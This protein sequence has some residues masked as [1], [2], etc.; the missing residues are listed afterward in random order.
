MN[1]SNNSSPP[2]H[3]SNITE[4]P[5]LNSSNSH[6]DVPNSIQSN[7][8]EAFQES[9]LDGGLSDVPNG[10]P[11]CP[12][13]QSVKS[14]LPRRSDVYRVPIYR[15]KPSSAVPS[16]NYVPTVNNTVVPNY[17]DALIN[18]SSQVSASVPSC[19]SS[20][21]PSDFN[22]DD[23]NYHN[24][25]DVHCFMVTTPG[26]SQLQN[27]Q[28]LDF[29]EPLVGR[30][31][32]S[33][34][35]GVPKRQRHNVSNYQVDDHKTDH[36][37]GRHVINQSELRKSRGTS[38]SQIYLSPHINNE[39]NT[40]QDNESKS[41]LPPL[42][43]QSQPLFPKQQESPVVKHFDRP[44]TVNHIFNN[45]SRPRES[46][47]RPC[48]Y[49]NSRPSQDENISSCSSSLESTEASRSLPDHDQRETTG[50]RNFERVGHDTAGREKLNFLN[51][52]EN[53]TKGYSRDTTGIPSPT[54]GVSREGSGVG[55]GSG[56]EEEVSQISA[57]TE[58][59]RRDISTVNSHRSSEWHS[60]RARRPGLCCCRGTEETDRLN[61]GEF[62]DAGV[63]NNS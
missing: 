6:A 43:S 4:S 7:N 15:P 60:R 16:P 22:Y 26:L 29:R 49:E 42:F 46:C 9:I 20:T 40:S 53:R 45:T 31:S 17:D 2:K 58:V 37:I 21:P 44:Q 61:G 54:D 10:V 18:R 30:R 11:S 62:D 48:Q 25:N 47:S 27:S 55:V 14:N 8:S 63:S 24:H 3:D 39:N 41:E 32:L 57:T 56:D 34:R 52:W 59:V 35:D 23:S 28:Q 36:E 33:N 38:D 51:T 19:S 1:R 50:S 12:N 5:V 13:S